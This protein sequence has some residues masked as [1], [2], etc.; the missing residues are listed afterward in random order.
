MRR[1]SIRIEI[2]ANLIQMARRAGVP[3]GEA[4]RVILRDLKFGLKRKPK[5]RF[6]SVNVFQFFDVRLARISILIERRRIYDS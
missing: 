4:R 5:N 1:R 3:F 6:T 2:R